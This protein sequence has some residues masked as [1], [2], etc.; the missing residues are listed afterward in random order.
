MTTTAV[1]PRRRRPPTAAPNR[2]AVPR[3][4]PE[5]PE[6]TPTPGASFANLGL[7]PVLVEAL[8]RQGLAAPFPIQA[9]TL[10]DALAG[11]DILG[12]GRTGSGKTLAFG[13]AV[14]DRIAGRRAAGGRPL[15]L[16]LVPTR[17]LAQQVTTALRPYAQAVRLRCVTVVGGLSIRAQADALARGAEVLIAT[18]GR[19]ADLTR[20]GRCR[21]DRVEVAV[22]DEADQMADIGFLPQVSAL[23]DQVPAGGQRMLFSATLDRE[24]DRLVRRFLTD[25]VTH[26][27]DPPAAAVTTMTHHLLQVDACDKQAT[28]NEIAGRDGQVM[29]FVGTKRGADR[30][31]R[32]LAEHGVAARAIHIDDLNLVVNIDPPVDGKDYLHRG[33]RTA[34][35]GR[36]GTVVTLVLPEQRRDVQR[37]MTSAGVAP[38]TTAIRP[39]H[40]ELARLTG[41]RALPQPAAPARATETRQHRARRGGVTGDATVAHHSARR[42]PRRSTA[43]HPAR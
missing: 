28:V 34:R 10:P 36:S 29:M 39:G 12:R 33:G 18:P 35:A 38:T 19:L 23:L 4:R 26:Q 21:L 40:P 37:L 13:L 17:E 41:A 15:A 5:T 11:R 20:Q 3:R 43:A 27:V 9:A 6:S 42:R 2:A 22:V 7:A 32:Q 30:L 24:V 14:L 8:R 31:A 25:P 16:V 1:S